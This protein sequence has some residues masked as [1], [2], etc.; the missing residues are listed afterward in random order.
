[1]VLSS[2]GEMRMVAA[3][4]GTQSHLHRIGKIEILR[5]SPFLYCASPKV[6][7]AYANRIWGG[8][9]IRVYTV[10]D[11]STHD[12]PKKDMPKKVLLLKHIHTTT[13]YLRYPRCLGFS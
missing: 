7:S 5:M 2:A 10:L 8:T 13:V 11:T 12:M 3:C 9:L 4:E 6:T 1:M